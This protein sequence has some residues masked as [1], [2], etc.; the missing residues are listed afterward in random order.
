M[1]GYMIMHNHRFP[2]QGG[3]QGGQR[4]VTRRLEPGVGCALL[5]ASKRLR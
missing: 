2:A 5:V 1:K 3:Q 4:A